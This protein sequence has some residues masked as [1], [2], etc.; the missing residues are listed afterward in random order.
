MRKIRV[1]QVYNILD[2][3]SEILISIG[4]CQ[5]NPDWVEFRLGEE[6]I[7]VPKEA[8]S[9]IISALRNFEV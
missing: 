7:S 9:G 6:N 3:N 5:D 2:E 1:D 4:T 8:V